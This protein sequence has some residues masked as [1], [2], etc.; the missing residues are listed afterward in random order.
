MQRM[1]RGSGDD[2]DVLVSNNDSQAATNE[3]DVAI[4]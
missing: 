2:T 1:F 3:N 4:H